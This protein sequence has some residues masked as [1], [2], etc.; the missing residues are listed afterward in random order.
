MFVYLDNA[1]TTRV[2]PD[3]AEAMQ[4]AGTFANPSS[5][6]SAGVE[7]RE[8]L[9]EARNSVAGQ[10]GATPSGIVFTSGAT[11]SNN[12]AILGAARAAASR[13]RHIVTTS[14]EHAAVRAPLRQLAREGF[15]TTEVAV[16]RA[17]R[18]S[19]A[20]VAAALRDD[21]V[22]V[23]IMLANNEI[24][25]LQPIA[26]IRRAIGDTTLHCDAA[27]AGGKVRLDVAELGVDLLTVSGHKMHGPRGVGVLFRNPA[28][29]VEPISYGGSHE[30]G[31]RPG[32]ENVAGA[33]GFARALALAH[34]HLNDNAIHMERLRDRLS[35][36]LERGIDGAT[37]LGA[38][39]PGLRLPSI[40]SIS[41]PGIESEAVVLALDGKGI[42]VSAGSACEAGSVEP[43]HVLRAIG[44]DESAA[45]GSL[46]LS[47]ST[48]TRE[49]EID[50]AVSVIPEVVTHFRRAR[51]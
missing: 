41:I 28:I 22:L 14:I 39:E 43:S 31:I 33:V 48:D 18:V 24:G 47:I 5:L 21:T 13:G 11:E 3:V 32:T 26:A 17:G 12:I 44:L 50:H 19:P 27:Q 35:A 38:R 37:V 29:P 15:E 40:L 46:R 6:H 4:L 34:R 1:A 23:T 16:D 49:N 45:R 25:T 36:A 7:A 42:A 2:H 51:E 9:E 30:H 8:I 20:D 10:L